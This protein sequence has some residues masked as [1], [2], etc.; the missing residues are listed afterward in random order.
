MPSEAPV[1]LW[2]RQ[3][4]RVSDNPALLEACKAGRILP[5]YILDNV[6]SGK[7]QMGAASKVWLHH[8]LEKLNQ[9]LSGNLKLFCGDAKIIIDSLVKETGSKKIFWNRCYEPWRISRDKEIKE[10]LKDKGVEAIS[11]NG[12]LLW[13]PWR[14]VKQD[15]TPY[16]VF[17]PYFKKGCLQAEPP[18]LPLK[19]TKKIIFFEHEI[20]KACSLQQL[21]LMPS[22]S[23]GNEIIAHWNVG[24]IAAQ[25]KIK[26][27][28]KKKL[29]IYSSET[30][31]RDFPAQCSTSRLSP[32]L[33]FGEVSP[34]QIWHSV[35]NEV[36]QHNLLDEEYFH[37]LSEIGWREF[38][39][40]LLYHWPTLPEKPFNKKYQDF[41]W[42]TKNIKTDLAKWQKGAT[43]FPI[44][45]A[46]M[47]ELWQT[48]TMHNRV[49]MIVASFL[50][51]N[52]LISWH[53]GG[54]WFWDCLFDADLASNSASW[55]WVA[56]CGADASP[57]FRIFN[58]VTQSEKF[59]SEGEYIKTYCPELTALPSKYIHKP[60][61]ATEEALMKANIRLGV[62]YPKPMLDL[63]ATRERALDMNK[64]LKTAY[65][66][67]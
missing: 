30:Q 57:Y 43:G 3:D 23:W 14:I 29:R 44:I 66:S 21:E 48:G 37:F 18:R 35:Q 45:D 51:K 36:K 46:G 5:I 38:S 64:K 67:I 55:Q 27:F 32:H 65:E 40:Y 15:G 11:T 54:E 4:L 7:W 61:Q 39:Y 33:H 2:F 12:S 49:R 26:T 22:L 1:I 60:W 10:A 58:P 56:G 63:K 62:D 52:Q 47:R 59:D 34:H 16:K 42:I 20:E 24:E 28:I 41:P 19:K 31:G 50:V 25:K 53:E 13:E 9:S 17:T 6:N 8:S